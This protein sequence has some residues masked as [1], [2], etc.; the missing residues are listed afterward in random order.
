MLQSPRKGKNANEKKSAKRN[1]L[2]N[3]EL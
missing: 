2:N 1:A 3:N